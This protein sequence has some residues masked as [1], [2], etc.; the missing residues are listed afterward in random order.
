MIGSHPEFTTHSGP[1]HHWSGVGNSSFQHCVARQIRWHHQ[2][3][4]AGRSGHDH[5]AV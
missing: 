2:Q 4:R 5:R 3:R 1:L